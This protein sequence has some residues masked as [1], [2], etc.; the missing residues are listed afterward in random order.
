MAYTQDDREI[1]IETPLGKDVLLLQSFQGDEGVSRLF[2]FSLDMVS[3]EKTI[4]FNAIVGKR[5]TIRLRVP[6][7]P[8]R[9]FNG[10]I[11]RFSQGASGSGLTAYTAELVPWLWMLTLSSDCRVFQNLSV[12]DIIEQVFRNRGFSDFKKNLRGT[13]LPL[14]YCVQ[15]RE[16]D[17]NFVSR[18]MEQYG[19]FYYFEHDK[20]AHHLVMTDSTA[21]H[22]P[23]P[24][25]AKASCQGA[26]DADVSRGEVTAFGAEQEVRAGRYDLSD[27]NFETPAVNLAVNVNAVGPGSDS[28]NALF[29][30][31]GEY[32]K[33]DQ[34]EALVRL[35][36]E[37]EEAQRVVFAGQSACRAFRPG[38]GFSL[39]D[40]YR[41]DWNRSYYL[42]SVFHSATTGAYG[43]SGQVVASGYTNSFSCLQASTPFRPPRSTARPVIEG[44]QTAMV[45]G[46][47]GEE[48][49]VDKHGRVKVQFHWDRKGKRDESSSCWV[50]VAQPWAG[51]RWG[52][53]FLPRIG[54]EVIVEFIEGDPDRPMIIGSV[55][56][57][58]QVPPYDLPAGQT[59]TT[60]KSNSS[61]GGGGSNEL[62]FEDKKGAEQVYVHGQRD[63]DVVV[64]HDRHESVGNEQHLE[65]T[66]HRI[67]KIG[68]EQHLKIGADLVEDVGGSHS[69]KAGQ[70]IHL[71]AGM[72]IIIEAGTEITL[73]GPSG[74]V[75]IDPSGV[76]IQ[77]PM[78]QINCGGAPGVAAPKVL[79][80]PAKPQKS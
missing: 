77:G 19:I 63:F 12:P 31:P 67:E 34:G 79:K 30:Y 13:Y 26:Q 73:K 68:G 61:K 11:S 1:G 17:F 48:V 71:N 54:Q 65:V 57:G 27:Y 3:T 43:S 39:T 78:V 46:K 75:K 23:C 74:F 53:V 21:G 55:Y 24:G 59:R 58:D 66:S 76:W 56:N 60:I 18:L 49:W 41:S 25:Q 51:K 70:E 69:E 6:K 80:T 28:K 44:V 45:V 42:L 32:A 50:R 2:R 7:Q 10:V 5:A 4:D 47:K 29:D 64:E 52:A 20:S 40:H 37:E 16:T 22:Q 36:I 15:Y 62:R 33:R 14:E 9:Y 38:Y 8:E 35:R 72:K